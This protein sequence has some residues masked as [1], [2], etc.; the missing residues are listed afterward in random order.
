LIPYEEVPHQRVRLP[1]LQAKGNYKDP[2]YPFHYIP[3]VY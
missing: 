3:Q 1:R 2:N